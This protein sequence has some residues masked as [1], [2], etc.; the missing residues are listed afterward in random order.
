MYAGLG[1]LDVDISVPGQDLAHHQLIARLLRKTL[2]Q[3]Y[4]LAPP[5]TQQRPVHEPC[6]DT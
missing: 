6:L 3:T 2:S 5:P 4:L 1:H